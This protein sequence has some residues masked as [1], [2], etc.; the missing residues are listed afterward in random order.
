MTFSSI[1]LLGS[2]TLDLNGILD[3]TQK[4]KKKGAGEQKVAAKP[5]LP[6]RK[7][8][9]ARSDFCC[10]CWLSDER[11]NHLIVD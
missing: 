1:L 11:D 10:A 5:V 4:K 8:L 9:E 2:I 3:C 6:P 7:E